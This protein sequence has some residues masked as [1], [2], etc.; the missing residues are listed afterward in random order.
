M[1]HFLFIED[2]RQDR[3]EYQLIEILFI[4]TCGLLSDAKTFVEIAKWAGAKESWLRRFLPLKNGIPSHDTMNRVFRMLN[5]KVFADVFTDWVSEVMPCFGQVAIDGKS[6][7]GAQR[8]GHSN[9]IHLVSAFATEMG[10]TLAYVPVDN[11]GSELTG[12]SALLE[13]LDLQGCLV[14][15]DALGCQRGL[16][17]QILERGGDYLFCAKGNQKK[18]HQALEAAF[19]TIEVP[20]FKQSERGHGRH[21]ARSVTAIANTGQVDCALWPGCRTLGRVLST[22]REGDKPPTSEIR[23]YISSRSLTPEELAHAVRNHWAIEN[24]LHWRLDVTLRED[25]CTVRSDNAPENLAIIR[26][27]ILNLLKSDTAHPKDSL[28][29]R[30][31]LAGWDDNERQRLLGLVPNPAWMAQ[32]S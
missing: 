27:Y 8:S 9:P 18:L 2:P 11:K 5:P 31:K 22:R 12:I 25:A 23:Y 30:F 29:V 10:L 7:R 16:A 15:L 20:T 3:V 26:R 21:I 6:L 24:D 4:V 19:D 14:S 17:H 28:N 32:S 13:A 1:E